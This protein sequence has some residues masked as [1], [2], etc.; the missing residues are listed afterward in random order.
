MPK[1]YDQLPLDFNAL[2]R[3]EMLRRATEFNQSMQ[4]RRTVRTF[5]HRPVE[6]RLIQECVRAAGSSPSGA[7]QQP[8]HFSVVVEHRMKRRI[9]LAAEEEEQAFYGGRAS[10]EWLDAVKPFGTTAAKPYLEIAPYLIAIFAQRFGVKPDGS[11]EKHYYVNE[12]VGIATGIL[13]TALHHAGLATLT[14]TPAPMN[15]LNDIL[16]RPSHEKPYLILVVGYPAESTT[17]PVLSRKPFED[18]CSWH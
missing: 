3:D 7:N 14:H 15:F 9:R 17:V 12:S 13:I 10:D 8:W 5:S 18:I 6:K 4:R 16:D 1:P 2:P 11:T